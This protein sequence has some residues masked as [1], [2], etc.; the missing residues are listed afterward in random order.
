MLLKLDGEHLLLLHLLCV[1]FHLVSL[2]HVIEVLSLS[3]FHLVAVLLPIF[4][5][6]LSPIKVAVLAST[7]LVHLVSKLT[8]P[9]LPIVLEATSAKTSASIVLL[10]SII[11]VKLVSALVNVLLLH[12]LVELVL[13]VL[14]NLSL[15]IV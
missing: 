8:W 15:V 4:V 3:H 13:I 2:L 9:L 12:I 1:L 10:V 11:V 7:S 5:L 6:T 14:R